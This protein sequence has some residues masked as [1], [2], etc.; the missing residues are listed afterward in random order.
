MLR[1]KMLASSLKIGE[2][3]VRTNYQAPTEDMG[4]SE[5]KLGIGDL[6]RRDQ[7]EPDVYPDYAAPIAWRM[8]MA[9]V[10]SRRC[11]ASGRSSCHRLIII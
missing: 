1:G 8:V 5:L 3:A 7:W 10:S 11:L 9:S 6:Y 2:R 4:I